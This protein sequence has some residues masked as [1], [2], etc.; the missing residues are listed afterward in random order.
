[1]N[2]DVAAENASPGEP[3]RGDISPR[4]TSDTRVQHNLRVPMRDGVELSLDLIRPDIEG[5]LPVVLVRTP[6]DKVM[7]RT[8]KEFY[9]KLAQRGY[10]VAVQDVRGRFNSDGEFFPYFNEHDDGYD[11]VEWIAAQDWCDGNIGM[12]GGSYVGQTPWFAASRRPPHLKAIAPIVSPPGT[13]WR[14]EPIYGGAFLLGLGEWLV[15]MGLRSWQVGEFMG[16][17]SEQ[18]DYFEALPLASL[19]ERAGTTSTWWPE[20]M[21]HPTFDDFWKRGSYDNWSEIAAPALNITGWWDMNFPGAPLNFENMRREGATPDSRD[22]QKLVIGP[23]PHWVNK[24]RSRN[25]VDFGEHAVI[26]LDDYITRFFDR[27]LKGARN[28]IDDEKPVYIFVLGAN[29]WWAEDAWPL[30]DT[31][32]VPFYLHSGGAANSLKGDGG[33]STAEPAAEPADEYR[34]DPADPVRILWGLHDGPVDDRLPSTRD[35]VLCYTSE[36][37][38]EP[39]DVVGWVTMRLWASSSALDTDW[40]ARLVDVYPDGS[41]RFLCHGVLRARFRDSLEQPTL[42][43]P[44]RPYLFEFTMNATGNRFLPGHR[45]RLELTSSWF[46]QYDRNTNS[47]A[48]NP[49]L[50]DQLVVAEQTVFHDAERASHVLLPV[51]RR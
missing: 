13:L 41:A 4:Q 16:I 29:E 18:Q 9:E 27:W 45:I 50:D 11:T 32:Q 3:P 31:E 40:H 25:D 14:N 39:L 24:H 1:V 20:M 28:G 35:D 6:Y 7:E 42:L 51:I 17:F 48:D 12:T 2:K 26:E 15:G 23:W 19:P 37:L 36:E 49:F 44:G 46:T 47:G 38:S 22:G 34:Y 43:E 33:L 21:K 10:I 8:G 5:P 30:P